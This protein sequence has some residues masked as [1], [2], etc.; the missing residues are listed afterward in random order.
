MDR[1]T[2]VELKAQQR[3]FF[4]TEGDVHAQLVAVDMIGGLDDGMFDPEIETKMTVRKATEII[5]KIDHEELD[6]VD[7][8]YRK[9]YDDLQ[10]VYGAAIKNVDKNVLEIRKRGNEIRMCTIDW[11]NDW[12]S[13]L[14]RRSVKDTTLIEN[15]RE[16]VYFLE[17]G[18]R[19]Q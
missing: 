12:I 15:L 7:C 19:R 5:A 3:S 9:V 11:L 18:D 2:F 10:M 17:T 4:D 8:D 13:D 14:N 16:V 6:K 1:K